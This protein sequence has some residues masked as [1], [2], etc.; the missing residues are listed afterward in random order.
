MIKTEGQDHGK[1]GCCQ[2]S[3]YVRVTRF[4]VAAPRNS[5]QIIASCSSFVY[6]LVSRS[7]VRLVYGIPI[8]SGDRSLS[9]RCRVVWRR[10]F[11]Q[12]IAARLVNRSLRVAVLMTLTGASANIPRCLDVPGLAVVLVVDVLLILS[13]AARVQ[14]LLNETGLLLAMVSALL[15]CR[16]AGV[17]ELAVVLVVGEGIAATVDASCA[18][19]RGIVLT[20]E[21]RIGTAVGVVSASGGVAVLL[22][23]RGVSAAVCVVATTG[24][25]AVL[26]LVD[27]RVGTA[28]GGGGVSGRG[29][30]S[31]GYAS[32]V[33]GG[34][35]VVSCSGV[36]SGTNS[37]R[38]TYNC[39]ISP[40][41]AIVARMGS[42][43]VIVS[44]GRVCSSDRV[45]RNRSILTEAAVA[46]SMSCGVLISG[47]GICSGAN[48]PRTPYSCSITTKVAV[49]TS[50]SSGGGVVSDGGVCSR[51]CAAWNRSVLTKT[52]VATS[53]GCGVVISGSSICTGANGPCTTY[54]C[55]I[56]TKVAVVTGLRGIVGWAQGRTGA[57]RRLGLS[58]SVER[59]QYHD[60]RWTYIKLVG[61][62]RRMG[63][64]CVMNVSLGRASVAVE[65]LAGW[66]VGRRAAAE[67][68]AVVGASGSS[69]SA[70]AC[71]TS[72]TN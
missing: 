15:R 44:G 24:T 52:A 63:A 59:T 11:V 23:D 3:G 20:I 40:E 50:V 21:C 58:L 8:R 64:R 13:M 18:D 53:L 7:S 48:G 34:G 29:G 45:T 37:T 9:L 4:H 19:G 30:R 2:L 6:W 66:V 39:S 41:V 60:G 71:E 1:F 51:Y 61:N 65:V 54:N 67:F 72:S 69:T 46:T 27:R 38:T 36:G 32:T 25:V 31:V 57:N 42:S 70:G 28:V 26:L 12:L 5:K 62:V 10:V 49:I 68:T 14:D 55:S 17:L 43:G 35:G 16:L 33:W 47:S 56:T 22:V